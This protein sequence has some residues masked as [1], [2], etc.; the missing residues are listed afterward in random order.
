MNWQ[1]ILALSILRVKIL[2]R[3]KIGWMTLVSGGILILVSYIFAKVSFINPEKIFWDF[4]LG[5]S[6]IMQVFL[7]TYLASHCL[8]EEQDRRTLHVLLAR[9]V[10]RRDWLLGNGLG[11][12]IALN[13][14]NL[15]WFLLS[16][17]VS[18]LFFDFHHS[19][20][21]VQSQLLLSFEIFL[22]IPMTFCFSLFLRP[23]LTWALSLASVFVLHDQSSLKGVLQDPTVSHIY[24]NN[25]YK[26]FFK[27]MSLLPPL[28][29]FDIRMMVGYESVF[30]W[31]STIS[32]CGLGLLWAAFWYVAS[33]RI[34]KR[35]DL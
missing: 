23:A 27:L 31:S 2:L 18:F 4:S 17:A 33:V 35:M 5:L 26:I 13:F 7:A 1:H 30:S 28:E 21:L 16:L 10:S 3:Q 15:F 12:W 14:M 19:F 9:G 25:F 11:F 8:K 29:W 24:Q 34:F 6:F 32:M 20:I 22:I